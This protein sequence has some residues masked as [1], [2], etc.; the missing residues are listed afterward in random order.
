[1]SIFNVGQ[2]PETSNANTFYKP[3][4]KAVNTVYALAPS[5]DKV[6]TAPKFGVFVKSGGP[7][8]AS[9]VSIGKHDVGLELGLKPQAK[10]FIWVFVPNNVRNLS[11]GGSP[12]L[13]E[14]NASNFEAIANQINMFG[15]DLQ[16]LMLVLQKGGQRWNLQ[17]AKPPASKAVPV[18]VLEAAWQEVVEKGLDG[19][20]QD[21]FGKVVGVI[22]SYELQQRFLIERAKA[23]TWN[24]VRASFG[25]PP[26]AVDE[27]IEGF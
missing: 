11:E 17:A 22:P 3:D 4:D 8:N 23:K 13:W 19:S 6:L 26:L 7:F 10:A 25:L 27:D 1:M 9:W 21:A 12:K 20:D 16:G 15:N 14:C 18:S 2:M 24:D 5:L